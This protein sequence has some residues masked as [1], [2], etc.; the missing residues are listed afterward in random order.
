M[1]TSVVRS[2]SRRGISIAEVVISTLLVSLVVVSA[3]QCV[4][5]I[6]QARM[7]TAYR[8]QG[9]QLAQD[10]L[11][12]ILVREYIDD[13][14]LPAFGPELWEWAVLYGNRSRYD[15]VDDYHNWNESPPQDRNGTTLSNLTGW[16]REVRVHWVY[17]ASPSS[18]AAFDTGLKRIT[19]TVKKDGQTLATLTALRA[20]GYEEL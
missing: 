19:V 20:E 2:I 4:S 12:E 10:M 14:S 9:F 18:A 16:R 6:M 13:G 1:K 17:P 5:G 3:L 7:E 8:L 15:D 11:A